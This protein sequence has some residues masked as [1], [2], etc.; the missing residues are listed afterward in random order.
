MSLTIKDLDRLNRL[1]R[2]LI[3][4]DHEIIVIE[5]IANQATFDECNF[6]IAIEVENLTKA[7]NEKENIF[8][9]DGSLKAAYGEDFPI[10]GYHKIRFALGVSPTSIMTTDNFKNYK[11][12]FS[13]T[14][15]LSILQLTLTMKQAERKELVTQINQL[16]IQL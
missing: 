12:D 9:S 14:Q 1:H 13:H 15:C 16:G 11:F 5:K 4:I 3:V 10:G 6:R 7:A 2:M 8:D